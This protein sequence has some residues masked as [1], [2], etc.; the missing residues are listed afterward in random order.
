MVNSLT[1]QELEIA[2][3]GGRTPN[4]SAISS[5]EYKDLAK[6]ITN[7]YN[8]DFSQA[9]AAAQSEVGRRGLVGQTGT[10][11]IEFAARSGATNPI[12][13]GYQA[14]KANLAYGAAENDIARRYGT[15]ERLSE[16]N[17]QRGWQSGENQAQRGWQTGERE[18]AQTWQ[19]K[20]SGYINPN[21]G[22]WTS[23]GGK[24]ASGNSVY[25]YGA[26]GQS[27]FARER[28]AQV[29]ADMWRKQNPSSGTK[30]GWNT[31]APLISG[32]GQ[33]LGM[34]GGAWAGN[35]IG[36]MF[37]KPSNEEKHIYG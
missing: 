27:S 8:Q 30:S 19:G 21:T 4:N 13:Q 15:S 24:D 36:G 34:V 23:F 32:A 14:N 11:D 5:Q 9:D 22:E 6:Q 18:G 37:K 16:G 31:V 25:G 7:Q 28:Q 3:R 20:M 33:G 2:K 12:T 1:P 10:S 17:L 35:K 26:A 29:D